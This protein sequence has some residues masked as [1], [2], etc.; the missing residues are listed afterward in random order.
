MSIHNDVLRCIYRTVHLSE[1]ITK[2]LIK[3]VHFVNES[4]GYSYEKNMNEELT[5]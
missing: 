3:K 1:L 2:K 5:L 4:I